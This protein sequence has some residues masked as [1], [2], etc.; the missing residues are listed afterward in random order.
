MGCIKKI[1]KTK[2][3]SCVGCICPVL[4]GVSLAGLLNSLDHRLVDAEG[5]GDT[6]QGEQQVGHHADDAECRQ[7]E[8][9]QHRH[10]KH[11]ARLLGVSPVD[12]I[13]H[14]REKEEGQTNLQSQL[15]S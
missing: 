7:R 2:K 9:Q 4:E 5:D 14:C 1:Q 6:E 3:R 8:Q 12:Q 11:Q 13:L 10:A 15:Y